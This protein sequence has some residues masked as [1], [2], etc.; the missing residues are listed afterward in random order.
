MSAENSIGDHAPNFTH[1]DNRVQ[2]S[3]MRWRTKNDKFSGSR[4]IG[5]YVDSLGASYSR[6]CASCARTTLSLFFIHTFYTSLLHSICPP[7]CKSRIPSSINYRSKL[8][9]GH[10]L[11]V[12]CLRLLRTYVAH[13]PAIHVYQ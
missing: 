9:A 10:L 5:R 13:L 4:R 3:R 7:P 8:D 12:S 2:Q 11:I 1:E 6:R